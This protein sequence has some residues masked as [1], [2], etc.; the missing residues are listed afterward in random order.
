MEFT[1]FAGSIP[2]NYDKY[3]GPFFFEPYALDLVNRL[4]TRKVTIVLELACGTG[5]VTKH[6]L[7]LIPKNGQLTVS[8]LNPDMITITK[9]RVED[10]KLK[11]QVVDAQDLPFGENNFDTIVCQFGVMFFP[12][13]PKAFREAHRVLQKDGLFIFNTWDSV[14]THPVTALVDKILKEEFDKE[15]PN[16][17]EEGP[18]SFYDQKVI[19][20]LLLDAVSAIFL[21]KQ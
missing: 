21:L 7:S 11:W 14:D 8:D 10:K 13:K 18:F 2:A 19:N 17:V 9:K 5:R 15:A 16:F 1:A 4:R 20:Q 12:D 3:L 6:L